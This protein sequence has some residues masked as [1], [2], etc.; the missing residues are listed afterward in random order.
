MSEPSDRVQL[1]GE[2]GWYWNTPCIIFFSHYY[3]YLEKKDSKKKTVILLDVT[4]LQKYQCS[5]FMF[6][7]TGCN[8]ISIKARVFL[9][10]SNVRVKYLTS[11]NDFKHI[12]RVTKEKAGDK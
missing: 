9:S 3:T 2:G 6:S 1:D 7:S 8:V 11:T 10:M 5:P 4:N 12:L